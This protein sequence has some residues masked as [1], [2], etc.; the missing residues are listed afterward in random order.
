MSQGLTLP[1]QR[2]SSQIV[3]SYLTQSLIYLT[4]DSKHD[5]L[6]DAQLLSAFRSTTVLVVPI[7]AHNK[8]IGVILLGLPASVKTLSVSDSKLVQVIAQQVGLCFFLESMQARKTEEIEIE[9]KAAISMTARKFAHEINNPLGIITN[10][11]TTLR[12]K[13]SKENDIQEELGVIGEEIDRISTMINQMDMFSNTVV[14]KMAL[15]DVNAVIE[16]IV[17]IFKAPLSPA[18]G[19][20]ITFIPDGQLPKIMTSRD[21]LKQIII[22]LLKNAAEAIAGGGTIA[23][24]TGMFMG[25]AHGNK[26]EQSEEIEIVVDD[27]GPGIAEAIMKNLYKPFVTTKASGHSGLGLSIVQKTVKDLGGSI[28]CTS[29]P[30]VGTRFSIRLPAVTGSSTSSEK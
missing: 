12:L 11:L 15:T 1:V 19:T 17:H 5:N 28:S 2:S 3:Q 13:L 22:N 23:V 24:R 27:T 29:R 14:A 30:N 20:V 25:D 6:A 10:Y 9:R 18:S 8:P 7:P 16:D 21:A 4:S 26:V